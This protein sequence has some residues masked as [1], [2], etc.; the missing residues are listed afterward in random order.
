MS[1]LEPYL[2]DT[3]PTLDEVCEE[4]EECTEECPAYKFCHSKAESKE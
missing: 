2:E 4:Y 3:R 1:E